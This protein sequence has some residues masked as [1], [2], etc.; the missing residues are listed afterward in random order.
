MQRGLFDTNSS[1]NAPSVLPGG[2]SGLRNGTS[3]TSGYVV[4]I[5]CDH[6]LTTCFTACFTICLTV[7]LRLCLLLIEHRGPSTDHIAMWDP[8]P[9][10]FSEHELF[11]IYRQNPMVKS[12]NR[13]SVQGFEFIAFNPRRRYDSSTA[14]VATDDDPFLCRVNRFVEVAPC[15]HPDCERV[16]VVEIKR[17]EVKTNVMNRV[18]SAVMSNTAVTE[19]ISASSLL[20]RLS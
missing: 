11:A 10:V 2:G 4:Y 5:Q 15:C 13:L 1:G 14:W 16:V 18:V 9:N 12:Y 6:I 7:Y 17:F 8:P 20:L 3:K 19:Y